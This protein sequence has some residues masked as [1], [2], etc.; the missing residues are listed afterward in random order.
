MLLVCFWLV[1]W[2]HIRCMRIWYRGFYFV[3]AEQ[4][5]GG[6]TRSGGGAPPDRGQPAGLAGWDVVVSKKADL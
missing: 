1:S 4:A 5:G 6:Q 3:Q 2:A